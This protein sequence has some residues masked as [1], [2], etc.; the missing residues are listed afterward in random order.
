MQIA[1]LQLVQLDFEE[2]EHYQEENHM[3]T[4]YSKAEIE[5]VFNDK[6]C[7]SITFDDYPIMGVRSIQ[8]LEKF[9]KLVYSD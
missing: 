8:G 9:I 1:Q 7:I 2:Q 5:V 4:I 6:K 3:V